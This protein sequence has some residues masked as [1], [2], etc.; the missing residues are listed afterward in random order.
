MFKIGDEV[1]DLNYGVD[2]AGIVIATRDYGDLR[3]VVSFPFF[4]NSYNLDGTD[5][6]DD[7]F[8][9]PVLF[10]VRGVDS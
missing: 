9:K 8:A 5:V 2:Y 4:Q 3:V 10:H 6:L 7:D 1:F